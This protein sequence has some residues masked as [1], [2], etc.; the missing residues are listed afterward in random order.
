MNEEMLGRSRAAASAMGLHNVEFRQ[1]E[2]EALPVEEGWADVVISNLCAHKRQV[3]SEITRVPKPGGR[4]QFA[5]IANG[6]GGAV[7]GAAQHR[8]V[9]RLNCRR[10]AVRRLA[11]YARRERFR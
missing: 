7:R 10:P 6:K 2:I 8:L 4:R 1:G 5:D 9:D 11:A 3:F